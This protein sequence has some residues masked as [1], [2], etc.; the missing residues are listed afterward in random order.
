[1]IIAVRAYT[2]RML[3][4]HVYVCACVRVRLRLV[5][6]L[7]H[8]YKLAGPHSTRMALFVN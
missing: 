8:A 3:L 5:S 7:W 6:D 1:M 2:R 4:A